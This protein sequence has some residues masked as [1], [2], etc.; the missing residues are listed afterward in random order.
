MVGNRAEEAFEGDTNRVWLIN[1]SG[2]EQEV[3]TTYK[4]RIA[5]RIFDAIA[6]LF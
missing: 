1:R 6:G 3:A 5:V 4:S 2:R